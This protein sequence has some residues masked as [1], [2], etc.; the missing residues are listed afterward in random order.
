MKAPLLLIS[1][2]VLSFFITGCSTALIAQETKYPSLKLFIEGLETLIN[3]D[4]VYDPSYRRL[5][6]MCDD[7]PADVGV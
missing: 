5:D 2:F 4:I 6:N 1:Y 7:V 3:P